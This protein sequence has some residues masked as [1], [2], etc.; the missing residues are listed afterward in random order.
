MSSF[1]DAGGAGFGRETGSPGFGCETGG[2]AFVLGRII[3]RPLFG[4]SRVTF[5]AVDTSG[6]SGTSLAARCGGAYLEVAAAVA[7]T[8]L[9]FGLG[10]F[11]GLGGPLFRIARNW[12]GSSSL[13]ELSLSC[14]FTWTGSS[15][16]GLCSSSRS[17]VQAQ[18]SW[19][20]A[21]V[22]ADGAIHSDHSD[23][24]KDAGSSQ[25]PCFRALGLAGL[26]LSLRQS[27]HGAILLRP[28][29]GTQSPHA[30][31]QG[32]RLDVD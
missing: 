26:G 18:P 7:G 2:L 11:L 27:F 17:S 4:L 30:A 5:V 29:I 1:G 15:S 21:G 25:A 14:R 19:D 31:T 10:I 9:G 6:A 12:P 13:E 22:G 16:L 20:G 23:H 8:G 28:T 24:G 3:G 32:W